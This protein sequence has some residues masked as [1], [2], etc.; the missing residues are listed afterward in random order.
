ME[1]HAQRRNSVLRLQSNLS[2]F[3]NQG[4]LLLCYLLFLIERLAQLYVVLLFSSV[5]YVELLN[6]T[7]KGK[8]G[9]K[10]GFGNNL[11]ARR[12]QT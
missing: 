8:V 3:H 5:L 1:T 9:P 2:F 4:K 6:H 11:Q 7:T 12:F 10:P